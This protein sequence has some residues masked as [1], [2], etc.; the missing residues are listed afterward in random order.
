METIPQPT[1]PSAVCADELT[2]S[3]IAHT[4]PTS[5]ISD[6]T[7]EMNL[8]PQVEDIKVPDAVISRAS[9]ITLD[10]SQSTAVPE[11]I[12]PSSTS[13]VNTPSVEMFNALISPLNLFGVRESPPVVVLK[14]PSPPP[15]GGSLTLGRPEVTLYSPLSTLGFV[16]DFGEVSTSSGG[17]LPSTREVE[18]TS[19]SEVIENALRGPTDARDAIVEALC[20]ASVVNDSATAALVS[21]ESML[22]APEVMSTASSG[23]MPHLA[24]PLGLSDIATDPASVAANPRAYGGSSEAA[25]T[26]PLNMFSN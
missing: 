13:P 18:V 6:F 8:G 25:L 5:Q 3:H 12:V 15:T 20:E 21:P 17:V 11:S 2:V 23:T 26:S 14:E 1:S 24:G 7:A 19:T 10:P 9:I 22:K 4:L 16:R